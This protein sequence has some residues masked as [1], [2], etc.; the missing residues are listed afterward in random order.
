M[1]RQSAIVLFV[2]SLFAASSASAGCGAS[3]CSN[4]LVEQYRATSSGLWV[5][6]TDDLEL[7]PLSVCTPKE[8]GAFVGGVR[9]TLFAPASSAAFQEMK[10]LIMLSKLF[11][12]PL[13]IQLQDD[14]ATGAPD[15]AISWMVA[16]TTPPASTPGG[17]G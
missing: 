16:E 3:Y 11:G 17:G 6:I 9:K 13:G 14:P 15:C 10:E 4:L 5:V 12:E 1:K 8:Y 7:S 2:T